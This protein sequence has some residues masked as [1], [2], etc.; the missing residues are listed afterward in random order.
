M[1]FVIRSKILAFVRL[2][3]QIHLIKKLTLTL[4]LCLPIS[5]TKS[6]TQYWDK[7]NSRQ[8]V[9]DRKSYTIKTILGDI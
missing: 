9:K 3:Y 4:I 6:E 5:C 2:V 7:E 8:A 1:I